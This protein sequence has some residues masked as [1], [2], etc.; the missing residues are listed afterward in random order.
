MIKHKCKNS[1]FLLLVLCCVIYGGVFSGLNFL[2]VHNFFSFEWEDDAA[3]NQLVYNISQFFYPHQTIF[4]SKYFFGHFTIIYFLIALPYRIFP[5]IYTLYIIVSFLYGLTA[6][7]VYKLSK[8]LLQDEVVSF[9]VGIIYLL[10]PPLHYVNLGT[11]DG[12]I[13]SIPLIVMAFYSMECKKYKMYILSILLLMFCKEDM[14]LVVFLFS[15]L[16]IV[17]KYKMK[18]WLATMAISLIY[19]WLAVKLEPLYKLYHH[20]APSALSGYFRYINIRTLFELEKFFVEYG[21]LAREYIFM[22]EKYKAF[23]IVL[24]PLL[25]MPLLSYEF[26][27]AIPLIGE[28]LLHRQLPNDISY[29]WA[30]IVATSI[31]G[32]IYFLRH[33]STTEKRKITYVTLT[34]III[35]NVVRNIPAMLP[36]HAEREFLFNRKY[37]GVNNIFDKKIYICDEEAKECLEFINQIPANAKVTASGDLL[38]ILSS[39]RYLYEFGMTVNGA[40]EAPFVEPEFKTRYDLYNVDYILIHKRN[41]MNGFGGQYAYMSRGIMNKE[42]ERIKDMGFEVIKENQRFILLKDGKNKSK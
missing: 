25:F 12:N 18:W 23:I 28:I 36:E 22:P 5:S 27:T 7:F 4:L 40:N 1:F 42:I 37:I 20:R 33:F 8:L 32:Y 26:Y 15:I 2:K 13:F 41:M 9:I 35:S 11:L 24:Y 14:P 16:M 30:P 38:P 34:V 3:E 31:I 29:Y 6:I 39:R 17:R 21:S 19:L 10:Y